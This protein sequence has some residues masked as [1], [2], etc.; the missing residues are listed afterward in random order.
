MGAQGFDIFVDFMAILRLCT[1]K[2]LSA[3]L[4]SVYPFV[5]LKSRQHATHIGRQALKQPQQSEQRYL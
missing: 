4:Y 3:T 1:G 2:K 5:W